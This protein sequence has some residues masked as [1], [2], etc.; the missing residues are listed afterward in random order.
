MA[1]LAAAA[2][3]R[4]L[5]LRTLTAEAFAP[6]GRLI[7]VPGGRPTMASAFNTS[8][9]LPF[10]CSGDTQL[11]IVRFPYAP[12]RFS[13]FERHHHV[14]QAFVALPGATSAFVVAPPTP[15]ARTPDPDAVMAFR[16]APGDGVILHKGT[17][18]TLGRLPLA[19][20]GATSLMITEAETTVEFVAAAGGG[21]PPRRSDLA[22]L[23]SVGAFFAI[24]LPAD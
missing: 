19:P 22:D 20:P 7:A 2:A 5:A 12:I 17:W 9:A 8:W 13:L 3:P 16:F 21:P 4:M 15:Y 24:D 6:F 18:H 10:A 14:S 23:A 1:T 11:A